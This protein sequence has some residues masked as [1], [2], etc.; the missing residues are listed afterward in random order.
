VALRASDSVINDFARTISAPSRRQSSADRTLQGATGEPPIGSELAAERPFAFAPT[1]RGGQL[2]ALT[3]RS[4]RSLSQYP[5]IRLPVAIPAAGG[6]A[7]ANRKD[8]QSIK[9]ANSAARRPLYTVHCPLFTVHWPPIIVAG[10]SR[11]L[12]L[13]IDKLNL[14]FE[15]ESQSQSELKSAAKL[16]RQSCI[17]PHQRR[18]ADLVPTRLDRQIRT[19]VRSAVAAHF[20]PR[21]APCSRLQRP[22]LAWR[23]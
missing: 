17:C 4:H 7:A 3:N 12:E 15:C 20:R 14:S 16:A 2:C 10:P 1:I 6:R 11:E 23:H 18:S 13:Q 5:F 8:K 9:A 21:E 19:P 22:A